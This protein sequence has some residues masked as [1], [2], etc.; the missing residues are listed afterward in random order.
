MALL[1][2]LLLVAVPLVNCAE[3]QDNDDDD[4]ITTMTFL[5]EYED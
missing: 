3:D 4:L 2:A 1:L 5:V